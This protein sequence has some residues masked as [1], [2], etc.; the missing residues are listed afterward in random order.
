[1]NYC[2]PQDTSNFSFMNLQKKQPSKNPNEQDPEP[3][4]KN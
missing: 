1:M 3:P 4:E 2:K